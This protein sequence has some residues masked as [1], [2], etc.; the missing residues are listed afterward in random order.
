MLALIIS[1]CIHLFES[2]IIF[3]QN[4]TNGRQATEQRRLNAV[5]RTLTEQ[6]NYISRSAS[7]ESSK[8]DSEE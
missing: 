1:G 8:P 3:L 2:L 6:I 5:N 7:V 4:R